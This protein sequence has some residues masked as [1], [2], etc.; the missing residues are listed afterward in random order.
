MYVIYKLKKTIPF[1]LVIIAFF[2]GRKNKNNS[3]EIPIIQ[4]ISNFN[5]IGLTLIVFTILVK[6]NTASILKILEPIIFP[7]KMSNS[8]LKA[9]AIDVA[10]SG[11]LVPRAITE[12]EMILSSM[13]ILVAILVAPVIKKFAPNINPINANATII[14]DIIS[15]YF[16]LTDSSLFFLFCFLEK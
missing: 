3:K 2:N 7:M 8:F 6:P 15:L 12:I 5:T 13:P 9:A 10:N 11:K 16:G 14:N 4:K 1:H